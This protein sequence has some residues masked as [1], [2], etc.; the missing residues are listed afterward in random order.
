MLVVLG[1]MMLSLSAQYYQVFLS[2]G[3]CI[4]LGSTL[5][6]VPSLA[7]LAASFTPA[8]RS[9]PMGVAAAGSSVGKL[10]I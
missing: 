6:W 4:G 10:S 9:L 2:Q 7:N 3:V 8:E 5:M 1:C